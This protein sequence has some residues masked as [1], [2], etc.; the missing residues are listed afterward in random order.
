M[1]SRK[2][3]ETWPYPRLGKLVKSMRTTAADWFDEKGY[4]V[5]PRMPYCLDKRDNWKNNI[6]LSEVAAYIESV[7]SDSKKSRRPFPLNKYVHHGLSSQAMVFNL[8]GPLIVTG[9]LEPLRLV[10]N[11]Q[12]IKWP[13]GVSTASFEY[14]DRAVFNED[15]AQPTSI[16]VVIKD[17]F[18]NPKLFVESKFVESEFGRCSVLDDGDCDGSNH[19]ND[20]SQCYLHFIGRTYWK[21]LDD[22]HFTP[23]LEGES[24]CVFG[25][26]YQFFRE[27]L[28]ALV[29]GGT[30]VLLFDE[31]S[32]VFYCRVGNVERGVLPFLRRFVPRDH[33]GRYGFITV[34]QLVESI[35]QSN[36]HSWISEFERK[37]GLIA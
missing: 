17:G 37:Y 7:K 24:F 11:Q 14:E 4:S 33:H 21:R 27:L 20:L 3:A 26:Y 19:M 8:V 16:D 5:H 12:G 15:V 25:M 34:K 10:V 22:A 18:G 35:K 9:D 6:V 32:P 13:E 23:M 31:R 30:F 28:M 36:R 2:L 29:K 1:N